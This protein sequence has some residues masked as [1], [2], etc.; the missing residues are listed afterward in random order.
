F[1]CTKLKIVTSS[2]L[3]PFGFSKLLQQATNSLISPL[4]IPSINSACVKRKITFKIYNLFL[5]H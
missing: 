5:N 4:F 1:F 3:P 2:L